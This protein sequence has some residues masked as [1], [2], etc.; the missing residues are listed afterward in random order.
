MILPFTTG[1]PP[2]ELLT[3]MVF[4]LVAAIVSVSTVVIAVVDVLEWLMD[5]I[6]F[7]DE[8]EHWV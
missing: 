3:A 8:Q 4:K 5:V 2:V 6:D 7:L 1:K